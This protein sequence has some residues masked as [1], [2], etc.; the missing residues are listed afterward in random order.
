MNSRNSR[1]ISGFVYIAEAV[2]NEM[3]WISNAV[4]LSQQYVFA[5]P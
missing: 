5:L 3:V 1:L 4:V 2:F